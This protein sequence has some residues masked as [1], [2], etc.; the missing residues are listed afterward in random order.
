MW[1]CGQFFLQ[2]YYYISVP[3]LIIPKKERNHLQIYK[4]NNNT[5]TINLDGQSPGRSILLWPVQ[6]PV[7]SQYLT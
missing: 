5:F 6:R 1:A 4:Y 7:Q 2:F 3:L